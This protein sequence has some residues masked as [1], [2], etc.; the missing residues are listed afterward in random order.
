MQFGPFPKIH[1]FWC[2]HL[3]LMKTLSYSTSRHK[4]LRMGSPGLR[5]GCLYL[6]LALLGALIL[7]TTLIIHWVIATTNLGL[8]SQGKFYD[9]SNVFKESYHCQHQ[10]MQFQTG[11]G[12]L[13]LVEGGMKVTNM[14]LFS[15][16]SVFLH[17]FSINF[18]SIFQ[19]SGDTFIMDGLYASRKVSI[20]LDIIKISYIHS[21]T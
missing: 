8:V 13:S 1:P 19:V 15:A 11:L 17:S 7:L 9:N 20:C 3:S 21:T 14:Y 10:K 4:I 12:S 2:P 6:C 5:T 16:W 18:I